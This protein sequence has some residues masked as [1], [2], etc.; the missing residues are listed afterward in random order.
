MSK[1]VKTSGDGGK[2]KSVAY[3]CGGGGS[4]KIQSSIK[5]VYDYNRPLKG[6]KGKGK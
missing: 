4:G 2:V 3:S 6:G 1:Y 5:P